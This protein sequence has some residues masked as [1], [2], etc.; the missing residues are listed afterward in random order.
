MASDSAPPRLR[1]FV[2]AGPCYR[3]KAQADIP[4]GI[5]SVPKAA[6]QILRGGTLLPLAPIAVVPAFVVVV[7][8]IPMLVYASII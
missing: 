2:S 8:R 4:H 3:A 6:K 7:A 1:T 5:V